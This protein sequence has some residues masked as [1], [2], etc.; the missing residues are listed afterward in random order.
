MAISD[1][2]KTI[3]LFIMGRGGFASSQ[4]LIKNIW[5]PSL[6]PQEPEYAKA[7]SSLSRSLNR[8]SARGL[9]D[10]Y[11]KVPGAGTGAPATIVGLTPDGA[12]W[13]AYL[14]IYG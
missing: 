5:G 1:L 14:E 3:L 7:H 9:I 6:T 12:E 13:A 2:Q 11:K 10:L 8:L 4:A